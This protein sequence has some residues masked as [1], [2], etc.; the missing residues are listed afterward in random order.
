MTME[1]GQQVAPETNS[2]T[3]PADPDAAKYEALRQQLGVGEQEQE[4]EAEPAPEPAV[5][6]PEAEP[7]KVPA[8]PEHVP[9]A[10]HENV[11]K[12]L[13]E[14]RAAEKTVNDRL[15]Q[16]MR[17]VEDARS[18]R[19]PK[20]EAEPDKPKLPVVEEDP[21]GHFN[22]RMA[23][24]EAALQQTHQGGQQQTQ[25]I[26]AH[27][28]EQAMWGAVTAAETEIRTPGTAAHKADYDDACRHL[29][30]SRVRQLDRMYPSDSAQ[31]QEM[32]RQMGFA[33]PNEYKLSLLNQD[34]RAVAV[35]AL[36]T[37]VSPA[38]LYYDLALDSGYAPK[39]NGKALPVDKGKQQVEALKRGKAASLSISGGG[40]GKGAES[41]SV[42]ELTALF[43]EDSD[44]AMKIFRK[45][46]EKGLL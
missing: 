38:Q 19:Q 20:Q 32:A 42:V 22:A 5:K 4:P 27:L 11:Q 9:Y 7:E 23:Q 46:G 13:R 45:M 34:R 8:K 6:E 10:E 39:P 24:L 16:F 28:Q 12:A 33:N 1:T 43:D 37:G 36:Q 35:H 29:E 26:Q 15:A 2:G 18:Q 41:M 21:I 3:P 17:I 25:Q 31:V 40:G 14:S 44:A 30:T